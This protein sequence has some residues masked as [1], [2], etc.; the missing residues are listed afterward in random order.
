MEGVRPGLAPAFPNGRVGGRC[1]G[2]AFGFGSTVSAAQKKGHYD[3][4]AVVGSKDPCVV[5]LSMG[6]YKATTA[7]IAAVQ[8]RYPELLTI[9]RDG[10]QARRA[11]ALAGKESAG[12]GNDRDEYPPAMF[13]YEGGKEADVKPIDSSDNRGAGACIGNE[14]RRLE[15]GTDVRINLVP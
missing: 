8:T 9:D 14:V 13:F 4:C 10:A 5:P 15:N 1:K 2:F 7:H 12:M 6:R 11:K 3:F